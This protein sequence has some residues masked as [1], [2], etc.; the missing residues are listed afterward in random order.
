VSFRKQLNT[1]QQQYQT[2]A[3]QGINCHCYNHTLNFHTLKNFD[4]VSDTNA[5]NV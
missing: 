2:T 1:I 4:I 3:T 5:T